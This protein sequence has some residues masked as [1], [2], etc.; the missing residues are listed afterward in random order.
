MVR[1]RIGRRTK[2]EKER[3]K[4]EKKVWNEEYGERGLD[5]ERVRSEGRG[6]SDDLELEKDEAVY[7]GWFSFFLLGYEVVF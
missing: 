6:Y 4:T 2:V 3:W 5:K 1:I 7:V